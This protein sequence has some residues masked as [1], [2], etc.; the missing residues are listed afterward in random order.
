MF[1]RQIGLLIVFLVVSCA[2]AFAEAPSRANY[3][4]AQIQQ[5]VRDAR[6]AEQYRELAEYY[7]YRQQSYEIRAREEK[8]EWVRRAFDGPAPEKYPTPEDASRNRYEYFTYEAARMGALAA[9]YTVLAT[10]L[11]Q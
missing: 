7:R 9:R 4:R 2:A 11:V 10:E 1:K 3:T 5:M 8:H 6:T